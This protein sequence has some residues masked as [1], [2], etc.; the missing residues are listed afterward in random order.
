MVISD[1]GAHEDLP[2]N[3][4]PSGHANPYDMTFMIKPFYEDKEAL[5]TDDSKVQSI[6]VLPTL[7]QIACGDDADFN[8]FEGYTPSSIPDDRVRKVYRMGKNNAFPDFDGGEEF[9]KIWGQGRFNC[10]TEYKFV[11]AE[12]FNFRKELFVRSIPLVIT[13]QEDKQQ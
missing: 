5:S 12:S 10:L 9:T 1:H 6:D 4:N 11:D 7:L 2:G 8:V 13:D 3:I